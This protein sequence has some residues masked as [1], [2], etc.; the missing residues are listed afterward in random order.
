MALALFGED[1]PIIFPSSE[2]I[3]GCHLSRW[4]LGGPW[5]PCNPV[6]RIGKASALLWGA[7]NTFPIFLQAL[8]RPRKLTMTNMPYILASAQW[9]KGALELYPRY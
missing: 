7:L 3:F 9:C 6:P 5:V 8:S 2:G 4:R 1:K